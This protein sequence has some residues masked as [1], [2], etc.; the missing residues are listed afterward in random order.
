MDHWSSGPWSY[1]MRPWMT[2][3][4]HDN[5]LSMWLGPSWYLYAPYRWWVELPRQSK[6]WETNDLKKR[7]KPRKYCIPLFG[8]GGDWDLVQDYFPLC[9]QFVWPLAT[10]IAKE[11]DLWKF[12]P[13][14][15]HL[16]SHIVFDTTKVKSD[17]DTLIK[18]IVT[19]GADKCCQLIAH[20]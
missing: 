18:F 14:L 6:Y 13:S 5:Q 2:A 16:P 20:Y 17:I 10:H 7:A 11:L 8:S 15:T 4:L 9:C 1:Y 12:Q 19:T 3:M